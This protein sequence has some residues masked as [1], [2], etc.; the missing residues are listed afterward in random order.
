[1]ETPDGLHVV[2]RVSTGKAY[3]DYQ[4]KV[5]HHLGS[6]G[7]PYA[8]P[9][10]VAPNDAAH[11]VVDDD[12]FW[13]LYRFIEGRTAPRSPNRRMA[14][15]IGALVG[16]FDRSLESLDLGPSTGHFHLQLFEPGLTARLEEGARWISSRRDRT[17]FRSEDLDDLRS[18]QMAY[19]DIPAAQ[20][21]EVRKLPK[22]T[23]YNDWHP[24]NILY[25]WPRIRGMIDFD[26]L[27]EAPRIIDFQNALT[28]ILIGKTKPNPSLLSAFS[29]GY[30]KVSPIF[31]DEV[32]LLCPAMLDRIVWLA[33]DIIDEVRRVGASTREAL[34]VRLIQLFCWMNEN[35]GTVLRSLHTP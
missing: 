27:V 9:T 21:E 28:Y 2:R 7:F 20:I 3:L 31:S 1:M 14:A 30:N 34:A 5:I 17:G 18:M 22:I 26:S 19:S 33:A 35:G 6:S 24:G 25:R 13:L 32:S 16:H 12:G 8:V 15:A 11:Y 23:V 10:I 29:G 4:V